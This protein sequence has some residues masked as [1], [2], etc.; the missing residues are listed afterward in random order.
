[1][2]D[3]KLLFVC[4]GNICRSPTAEAIA[5]A[6]IKKRGLNWFCDSAGTSGY[7]D[8]ETS[9]SRS[10]SHAAKRGYEITSIS[11][12]VTANDFRHFDWIF[13]M[14]RSNLENLKRICPAEYIVKL[15]VITDFCKVHKVNEV[16]DPYYGDPELFEKVI[17]ILEDA[18]KGALDRVAESK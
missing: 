2:K 12:K 6:Q 13:A 11:R 17:D 3:K 1:M 14:D 10:I 9:D 8:G 15:S 5:V 18:I 4:L 7:H 16:P